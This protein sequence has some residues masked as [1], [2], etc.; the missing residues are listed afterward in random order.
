MA[1]AAVAPD[2][3]PRQ[4]SVLV[5]ID[6][7]FDKR[8][9][10]SRRVALAPQSPARARPIMHDPARQRLVQRFPI[11]MGEHQHLA[12]AFVD[13][14][15]GDEP[16]R[17][18]P[19]RERRALFKAFLSEDASSI[20]MVRLLGCEHKGE[21]TNLLIGILAEDSGKLR[22]H[23]RDAVFLHA[24]HRHAHMLGLQHNGDAARMQGRIDRMDDL[25][26]SSPPGSAGG[27]E[28]VDDARQLGKTDDAAVRIIADMRPCRRTAPYG[29]RNAK[30]TE[31]REPRRMSA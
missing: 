11:H 24:A 19:R 17:R 14:H 31:C 6:A 22:R 2:L 23:G 8:L 15:A 21:E 4:Q 30:R 20:S 18:K 9:H 28:S 3:D 12:R 5:A 1:G 10:L 29:A 27:A 16:I 25:R 13:R 26:K 7:Q